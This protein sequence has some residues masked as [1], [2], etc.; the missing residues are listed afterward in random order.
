MKM[1]E[2]SHNYNNSLLVVRCQ[3]I[4]LSKRNRTFKMQ[5]IEFVAFKEIVKYLS[6]MTFLTSRCFL[7]IILDTSP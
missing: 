3:I 2:E 4:I 7:Y 1:G 6:A 5:L